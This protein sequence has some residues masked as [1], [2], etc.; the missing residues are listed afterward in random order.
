[1]DEETFKEFKSL[2]KNSIIS[3]STKPRL[4]S[5]MQIA[6]SNHD[7]F[8]HIEHDSDLEEVKVVELHNYP[9]GSD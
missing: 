6:A 7:A 2:D 5:L 1:M 8:D 9:F 3:E 4:F